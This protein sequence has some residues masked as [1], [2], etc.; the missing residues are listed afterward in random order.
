MARMDFSFL[1]A[2]S[3]QLAEEQG[4]GRRGKA[5]PGGGPLGLWAAPVCLRAVSP[6]S[7]E[8][9]P[10]SATPALAHPRF[11]PEPPR[12]TPGER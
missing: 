6:S 4:P 11:R 9:Q 10:P 1:S 7:Q 2:M 12:M 5:A 8:T 3:E